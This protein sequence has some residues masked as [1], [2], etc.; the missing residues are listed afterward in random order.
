[1]VNGSRL[2]TTL[3]VLAWHVV[4]WSL[5]ICSTTVCPGTTTTCGDGGGGATATD[6]MSQAAGPASLLMSLQLHLQ[7]Q[8]R[9]APAAPISDWDLR[10]YWPNSVSV[11][12]SERK[13]SVPYPGWLP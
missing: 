8:L 2:H 12:N 4:F 11:W 9:P 1:M 7:L 13:G 10:T 3:L 6:A 5:L